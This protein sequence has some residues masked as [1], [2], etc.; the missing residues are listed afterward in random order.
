MKV[1]VYEKPA[2]PKIEYP[3]LMRS[4]S[5]IVLFTDAGIGAVVKSD[6]WPVGSHCGD[7]SPTAFTPFTGSVTL[8]N[9]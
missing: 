3:C 6:Y 9:D 5:T 7:W 1:E 8:S 2:A 4:E